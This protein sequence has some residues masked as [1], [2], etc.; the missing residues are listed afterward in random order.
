VVSVRYLPDFCVY[1]LISAALVALRLDQELSSAPRAARAAFAALLWLLVLYSTA[2][3]LAVGL[4]G[5]YDQ[6]R[7][8]RPLEYARIEDF[9]F[10]LQRALLRWSGGHGALRMEL[11][12]PERATPRAE[13]LLRLDSGRDED[14]LC[15]R[16]HENGRVMFRYHHGGLPELRS[17][18]LH[19]APGALHV[20]ELQSGALY[21]QLRERVLKRVFPG[22]P[23][24]ALR[25]VRLLLDGKEILS[26]EFPLD[27]PLEPGSRVR[28]DA[29][30]FVCPAP[31]SGRVLRAQQELP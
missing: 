21:P 20:L 31:F 8:T 6:Y 2:F 15:V 25:R 17:D 12:L 4:T 30:A 1:L 29:P 3:N 24:D 27:L 19:L 11:A 5:Y 18:P 7:K 10:P 9:F 23:D 13:T 22:A 26:G 16:R 14:A 28:L